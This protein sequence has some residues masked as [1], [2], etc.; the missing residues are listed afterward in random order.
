MTGLLP[1]QPSL[2]DRCALLQAEL[3]LPLST[4]RVGVERLRE[5]RLDSQHADAAVEALA[6]LEPMLTGVVAL[7]CGRAPVLPRQQTELAPLIRQALASATEGSMDRV[8]VQ[9][10][11]PLPGCWNPWACRR[12][13][14]ELVTYALALTDEPVGVIARPSG[15]SVL[16]GV[17]LT[18][19]RPGSPAGLLLARELGP[20]P[21]QLHLWLAS[22]LAESAGGRVALGAD[23]DG[24][25]CLTA[26]LPGSLPG[27]P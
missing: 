7:A 14:H 19:V 5:S 27:D 26:V 9:L 25:A 24:W 4:V 13:V 17:H 18:G 16:L 15:A 10:E 22:R 20:A 12:T 6:D 1:N 23:P 11:G 8:R 2:D 21:S 3:A